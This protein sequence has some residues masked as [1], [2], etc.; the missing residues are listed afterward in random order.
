[1]YFEFFFYD[2][3]VL[4]FISYSFRDKLK[5]LSVYI[6]SLPLIILKDRVG[7]INRVGRTNRKGTYIEQNIH[8]AKNNRTRCIIRLIEKGL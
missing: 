2:S 3:S 7:H 4:F 5:H 8:R 1:M 6:D